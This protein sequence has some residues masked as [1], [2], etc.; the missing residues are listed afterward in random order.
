MSLIA[1]ERLGYERRIVAP[2]PDRADG[3]MVRKISV[4][5]RMGSLPIHRQ[6]PAGKAA[7]QSPGMQE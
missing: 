6:R 2:A 5:R 1:P 7:A 3:G 4:L